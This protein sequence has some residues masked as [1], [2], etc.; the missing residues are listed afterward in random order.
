MIHTYC[1]HFVFVFF[2][3]FFKWKVFYFY[4]FKPSYK[5][6]NFCFLCNRVKILNLY[7]L[8]FLSSFFF[9]LNQTKEFFIPT[10]F[11]PPN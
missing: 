7:E 3:L 4:F 11:H 6:L 2:I 9:F 8:H 10:L 5:Q 1:I